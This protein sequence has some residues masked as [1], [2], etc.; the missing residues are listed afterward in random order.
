MK[1]FAQDR[2]LGDPPDSVV[3]FDGM[4]VMDNNPE[5]DT[6]RL[7]HVSREGVSILEVFLPP[8]PHHFASHL[9]VMPF[10]ASLVFP[11]LCCLGDG[12]RARLQTR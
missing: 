12:I 8:F 2:N 10:S 3:E 1:I 11:L 7:L 5:L 9:A 4:L 6:A